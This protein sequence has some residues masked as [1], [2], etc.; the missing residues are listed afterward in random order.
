MKKK[1]I[2][3]VIY[4]GLILLGTKV[5]GASGKTINETTRIR[6]EASTNSDVVALVSIGTDIEIISE[7]G[8]WYKV[9]YS[10]YSGYMRKDMLKVEEGS[11]TENE[12]EIATTTENTPDNTQTETNSNEASNN[13]QKGAIR[14]NI[15]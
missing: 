3:I 7:E 8:E 11:K 5:Y 1:I 14:K 15:N 13:I 2:F 6:K 9:K 12:V 4:I 10:T